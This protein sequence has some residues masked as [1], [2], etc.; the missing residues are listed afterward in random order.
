MKNDVSSFFYYMWNSWNK[1]ECDEVFDEMSDYIWDEW[2]INCHYNIDDF[3]ASIDKEC[4]DKLVN[5][6]ISM[7]DGMNKIN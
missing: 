7:Y 5:R 1:N 3:Y 6:A 2:A 4:Q